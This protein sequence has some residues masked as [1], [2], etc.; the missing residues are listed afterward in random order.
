MAI[1][2]VNCFNRCYFIDYL[3]CLSMDKY[4]M[5]AVIDYKQ[6]LGIFDHIDETV[7]HSSP[8]ISKHGLDLINQSPMHYKEHKNEETKALIYGGAVHCMVLE[9]DEFEKKYIVNTEFK[10][11]RTNDAKKWRD[12]KQAQGMRVLSIQDYDDMMRMVDAIR[13]HPYAS[14]ILDPD[15]GKAE[16]SAY[17]ID[18]DKN[19][20]QRE[21]PTGRLCRCRPDF[22][23]K[24]HNWAVDLKTTQCAGASKFSKDCNNYRYHVQDAFY[25]DGL[26]QAG[27]RVSAFVFVAIEKKPP[28][29]IGIYELSEQDRRLGRLIYQRDM[30]RYHDCMKANEWPGYPPEIR[31]LEL[32]GYS[33][34]V[35]YY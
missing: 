11:F 10:D 8:G 13:A 15:C 9:P 23:N 2:G 26:R 1:S 24:V 28:Y 3:C 16:Q 22:I 18:N 25:T 5:N 35:D 29:G 6:K 32:P 34:Y 4:I 7:Y 27:V 12:E 20:W 31:T 33:K 19:I 14:I 30:L 21:D 17:W